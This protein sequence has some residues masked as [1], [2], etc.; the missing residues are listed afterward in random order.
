MLKCLFYRMLGYFMKGNSVNLIA[1][2]GKLLSKVI[3]YGFAFPVRIHRQI[4]VI[5]FF[6]PFLKIRQDLASFRHNYI[7]RLEI[8]FEIHPHLTFWQ[9]HDVSH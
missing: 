5:R 3:C 6:C 4:Y 9:V 2:A 1:Y 7:T 8:I